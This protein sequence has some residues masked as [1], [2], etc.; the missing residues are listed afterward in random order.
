MRLC[1]R[2]KQDLWFANRLSEEMVTDPN[3]LKTGE[4][5][6]NYG[7][8]QKIRVS[9]SASSGANNL[10][11]QGMAE[12]TPYGIG[13]GYTHNAVTE[14]MNCP[15]DEESIVW[16]G[17]EPTQTVRITEM[18]NGELITEERVVDV[19]YNYRVVRKAESLNHL[20]YYLKEVDVSS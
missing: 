19:P 8:P 9:V 12:L 13:T 5:K 16:Y 4:K 10:G 17:R 20:I 11:S 18:V 15:M 2:N 1:A 6:Q 14:D 3:G 7:E